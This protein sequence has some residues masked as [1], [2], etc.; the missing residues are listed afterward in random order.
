MCCSSTARRTFYFH[1]RRISMHRAEML[2]VT[3]LLLEGSLAK[4]LAGAPSKH[5][6]LKPGGSALMRSANEDGNLPKVKEELGRMR[7]DVRLDVQK[8]QETKTKV[9]TN[10]KG[11]ELQAC[12]SASQNSRNTATGYDGS[13]SCAWDPS[14]AGYH[15]VCV[16]VTQKFLDNSASQDANDLSSVISAG[17][18]WCICAWAFASSVTRDPNS[19][20]GLE[21]QCE[22]TNAKLREV[23]NSHASLDSP[24]G[25]K[26]ESTSALNFV[27]GLCGD[28]S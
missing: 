16:V 10:L 3:L 28:G 23:Y 2:L 15:E 9:D 5:A 22:K 12:N 17:D 21:L 4:V 20:E 13:G 18:T 26:Y 11:S 7:V 24:S 25:N 8:T 27:N 19:A 1:S 6:V 14:D